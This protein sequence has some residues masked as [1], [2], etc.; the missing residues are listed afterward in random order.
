MLQ[1]RIRISV[2][3]SSIEREPEVTQAN[4]YD[5]APDL[6]LVACKIRDVGERVSLVAH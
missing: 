5:A 1:P 2:I 3:A 4:H 6:P